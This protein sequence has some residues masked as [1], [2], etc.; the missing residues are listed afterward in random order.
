MTTAVSPAPPF[1]AEVQ[2][3]VKNL[4]VA[5]QSE[6]QSRD[7]EMAAASLDDE[8]AEGGGG[9]QPQ[10]RL[11]TPWNYPPN[12]KPKCNC[13]RGEWSQVLIPTLSDR[14]IRHLRSQLVTNIRTR[15]R[16]RNIDYDWSF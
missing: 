4:F 5:G 11:T 1:V 2:P 9:R 15:N 10:V 16:P 3:F 7:H 14:N 8:D 12:W 13:G 6:L